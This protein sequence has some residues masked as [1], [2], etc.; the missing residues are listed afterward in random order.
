M[1][2]INVYSA[3]IQSKDIVKV[4]VYEYVICNMNS[5]LQKLEDGDIDIMMGLAIHGKDEN[6]IFNQYSINEE[7]FGIFGKENINL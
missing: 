4:G 2:S 6:I 1:L 7:K 5:G 3:Q